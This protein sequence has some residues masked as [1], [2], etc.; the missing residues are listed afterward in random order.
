MALPF[1]SLDAA[2]ATGPGASNDLEG[3]YDH[4]TLVVAA[5]GG[6]TWSVALEGS[7]DGSTWVSLRNFGTFSAAAM[8]GTVPDPDAIPGNLVRY[9]RANLVT[10]SGGTNPTVTVTI[11]TNTEEDR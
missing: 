7:H 4:H 10:L 6:C 11:A 8:A 1:V 2:T 5:T 3:V 9:V